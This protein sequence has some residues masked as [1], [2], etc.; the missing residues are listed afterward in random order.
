MSSYLD[1]GGDNFSVFTQGR[2]RQVGALDVDALEAYFRT[3][4]PVSP[5]AVDRITRVER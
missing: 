2:D 3:Q 4:S 1:S 5:P